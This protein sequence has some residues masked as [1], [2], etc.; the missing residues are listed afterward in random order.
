MAERQ[1]RRVASR[2]SGR[3]TSVMTAPQR[4]A[5]DSMTEARKR[6]W[7][8]HTQYES[9]NV[10]TRLP[11]VETLVMVAAENVQVSGSGQTPGTLNLNEHLVE[12]KEI[13]VVMQYSPGT[14]T[15]TD[16]VTG[17][18]AFFRIDDPLELSNTT[19]SAGKTIRENPRFTWA[20]KPFILNRSKSGTLKL[21]RRWK[22]VSVG[23]GNQFGFMV[24]TTTMNSTSG[25]SFQFQWS[26]MYREAGLDIQTA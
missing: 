8:W 7:R 20:W 18:T 23:L 11:D 26:Y 13:E 14:N 5:L 10:G 12:A 17:A 24:V 9:R 3:R 15:A 16:F 1:R 19:N 4:A 25:R 6:S 21:T 22:G 2:R